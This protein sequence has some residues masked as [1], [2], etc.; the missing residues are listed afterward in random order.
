MALDIELCTKW[1][2]ES[3]NI[4]FNGDIIYVFKKVGFT[5]L[6]PADYEKVEM[7][8]LDCSPKNFFLE[9]FFENYFFLPFQLRNFQ[10]V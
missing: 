9:K 4:A 3:V 1:A 6:D 2:P 7:G 5:P 10:F 8:N